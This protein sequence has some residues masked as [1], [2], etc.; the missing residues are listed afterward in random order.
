MRV[1]LE[2][3]DEQVV[4]V[5]DSAFTGGIAYWC[6]AAHLSMSGDYPSECWAEHVMSG[7]AVTLSSKEEGSHVLDAAAVQRGLEWLGKPENKHIHHLADILHGWRA[8]AT[9]GDVLVQA[10]I[11]G[12]VVY[13]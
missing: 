10:A 12:E 5:L 7:G 4:S 8:D 2:V 3:S 6:T 1:T 11:F 9:T 13:G